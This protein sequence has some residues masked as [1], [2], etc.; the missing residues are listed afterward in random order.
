MASSGYGLRLPP[1]GSTARS[2]PPARPGHYLIISARKHSRADL[3]A[4]AGVLEN[5]KAHLAHDG[6]SQW[7]GEEAI[8]AQLEGHLET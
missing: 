1:L 8:S 5:G 3:L 6:L 7:L 4:L 2:A